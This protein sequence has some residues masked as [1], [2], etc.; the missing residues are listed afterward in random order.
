MSC[1]VVDYM[2]MRY[3]CEA[4]YEHLPLATASATHGTDFLATILNIEKQHRE[5]PGI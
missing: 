3:H 1:L 5:I 4:N 2:M